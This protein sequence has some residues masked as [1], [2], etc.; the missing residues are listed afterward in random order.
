VLQVWCYPIHIAT[1]VTRFACPSITGADILQ[2]H[3][4]TQSINTNIMPIAFLCSYVYNAESWL[5][6]TEFSTIAAVSLLSHTTTCISL[7]TTAMEC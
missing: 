2:M 6:W 3:G 7:Y 1:D 4:W 5:R